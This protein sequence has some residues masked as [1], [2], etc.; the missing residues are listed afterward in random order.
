M[1]QAYSPVVW[2]LPD[3]FDSRTRFDW[4]I[5]RL[6]MQS[7]PGM[8]YMREAPTNGKW[9]KWDGVE[10]DAMQANRLWH[11]V[12]C[13]LS[14]DWEHVI[15]VFIKQE[16]HKKHKAREGRWRLIMASSLPVQLVWHM[17]FSYMNDLEISECYNIPSQ[18]G[19][20]LVGGGWK[21]YLR[22]WKEEGL[23]VGLDK[24]A[25]DWTAPRWVM[26]WDLDFRYRMGRGKRMEEWHRLAKL[27]YHHMF[28]HPVLQLSDG[29][30]L[31]QTV[32]GIMKSGCVNTISTNGHAQ[33]MMHCVVAEDSNVPY[34]P[35]PKTCGDDTLE[36]PMHT[37][38]L[39]YYGRYGVVV[40]S[41]SENMEFVGHEFTDS[42]P[43]PLYISK[44]MKKLQY[45]A[46]DI[47]PDF[48]DAMARMYVHTRYFSI[49]E[50]LAIVNGTP[51]PMSKMA[52]RYWYDF[53]V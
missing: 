5:R 22:S 13:V 35:Y 24:S 30:L 12:Q 45:L 32:P 2:S 25:W 44:H 39:E 4:A 36:H 1:E 52:Y 21:D 16:P 18:H 3:D 27:M 7:S 41:V 15:R 49:W 20:I 34:E 9:L 50:D 33:V 28:D 19:L 47:I 11:D 48:L 6:D 14:D 51:L 23:S 40:K 26:D 8:P 31:R 53:S 37:Q 43:H 46:D 10:Y 42:G 38:S 29:T 17:L